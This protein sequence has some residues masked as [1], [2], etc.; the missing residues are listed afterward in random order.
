VTIPF[1]FGLSYTSFSYAN[2]KAPASVK[3]CD[4]ITVT[5]DVTNTGG[6]DGEEVRQVNELLGGA[7]CM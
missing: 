6:R 1:G 2:L 3:A 4:T 7:S 5:V